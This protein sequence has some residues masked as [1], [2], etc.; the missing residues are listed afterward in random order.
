MT[1]P[2]DGHI[3]MLR[4]GHCGSLSPSISLDPANNEVRLRPTATNWLLNAEQISR[5]NATN[6]RSEMHVD[7][8]GN[9]N[10]MVRLSKCI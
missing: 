6:D 10:E 1:L 2:V 8:Y 9:A 4:S 5:E 7:E 3:E